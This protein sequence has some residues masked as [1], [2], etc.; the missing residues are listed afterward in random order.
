MNRWK[1]FFVRPYDR[2]QLQYL[3]SLAEKG[4]LDILSN[5][6]VGHEG[7]VLVRPQNV[8]RIKKVFH[9]EGINFWVH[10]EDVKAQLEVDDRVIFNKKSNDEDGEDSESGSIF[11]S[12]QE[13][14]KIDSFLKEIA[15]KNP[16]LVTLVSGTSFEGRPVN[17]LKISSSKFEDEKKPLIFIDS[18]IHGR[19]WIAPP[20]VLYAINELV[21]NPESSLTKNMDWILLPVVNPDGYKYT[22][23]NDRLWSK[24]RSTDQH[25]LS[26]SCPGVDVNRNFDFYWN[27]FGS[28]NYPCLDNYVGSRAFSEL[29]TRVV[30]DIVDEYAGRMV[31]YIS[32]HSYGSMILYPWGHDGSLSNQ[33]FGLHTVGVS[34][35]NAIASNALPSFPR[36]V[37][38]NSALVTGQPASGT[39]VDYIH[40]QGVPLSYAIE[41]PGFSNSTRGFTLD[42]KYIKQ[43]ASETW[44]GISVGA[45]R[46]A[47][48]FGN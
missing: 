4:Y 34:M 1:S 24:T 16:E 22:F 8:E 43:V 33:A 13:L 20:V 29:E 21:N 37:V 39:S 10:A 5:A 35:A 27:T 28:S 42:P 18:G 14:E 2:S 6:N 26:P 9:D 3:G 7:V 15:E 12:Y 31:M 47:E 32:L 44:A 11:D 45:T 40:L 19:E 41:L 30:K 17:Y 48:L 23:T 36:Y 46:A 38:G 25:L